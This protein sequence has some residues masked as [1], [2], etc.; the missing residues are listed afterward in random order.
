MKTRLACHG[1]PPA[2]ASRALKACTTM[3]DPR[4]FPSVQLV[5]VAVIV[6][7]LLSDATAHV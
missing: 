1:D 4:S 5:I 7:D 2:F 6:T 3:L